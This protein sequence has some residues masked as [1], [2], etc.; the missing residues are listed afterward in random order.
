MSKYCPTCGGTVEDPDVVLDVAEFKPCR[1][2]FHRQIILSPRQ[3]EA[4]C[5][6]FPKA[7]GFNWRSV[8]QF[9]LEEGVLQPY[10]GDEILP[11]PGIRVGILELTEL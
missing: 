6:G 8:E 2:S 9:K 7:R 10:A 1:D 3:V 4:L 11:G 5:G